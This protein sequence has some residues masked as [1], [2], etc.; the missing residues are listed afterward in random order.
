MLNS[1]Q[2]YFFGGVGR[3][4][5]I[6]RA[7]EVPAALEVQ[8]DFEAEAVRFPQGMFI[9]FAPGGRKKSR[10]MR[11]G[12]VS[13]LLRASRI[14]QH[15]TAEAFC[16]HFREVMGDGLF[17]DIAVEPPP[18]GAQTSFVG[19]VIPATFEGR[20]EGR[21]SEKPEQRQGDQQSPK[22]PG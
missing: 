13:L 10:A 22:I 15:G 2:T 6:G 14:N 20:R 9:K 8:T 11:H 7:A 16:L 4:D 18:I 17:G 21:G 5:N 1:D 3:A 19:W 12:G